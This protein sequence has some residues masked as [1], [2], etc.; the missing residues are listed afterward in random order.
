MILTKFT[1][2]V[3][4][5]AAGVFLHRGAQSLH[6]YL[7]SDKKYEQEMAKLFAKTDLMLS[8]MMLLSAAALIFVEYLEK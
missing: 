5:I 4:C 2:I 8:G 1:R 7:H 3:A 6:T